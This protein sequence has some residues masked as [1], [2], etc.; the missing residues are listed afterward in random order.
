MLLEVTEKVG[1]IQLHIS[2]S[3]KVM[4][5]GHFIRGTTNQIVF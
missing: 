1:Q 5:Q 4:F 2:W 3:V